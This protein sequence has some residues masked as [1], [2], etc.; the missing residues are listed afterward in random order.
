MWGDDGRDFVSQSTRERTFNEPAHAAMKKK[1][2]QWMKKG[3]RIESKC[4]LEL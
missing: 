2:L 3:G 4:S 1:R